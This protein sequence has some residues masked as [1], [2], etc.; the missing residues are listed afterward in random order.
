[1]MKHFLPRFLAKAFLSLLGLAALA[2]LSVYAPHFGRWAAMVML[3]AAAV[4]GSFLC[5]FVLDKAAER[6]GEGG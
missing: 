2:S 5:G 6:R 1:M 4:V 3:V